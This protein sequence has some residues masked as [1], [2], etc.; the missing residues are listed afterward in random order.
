MA[1]HAGCNYCRLGKHP[2]TPLC[3]HL[4]SVCLPAR[5]AFS[6]RASESSSVQRSSLYYFPH[7]SWQI[8]KR[9]TQRRYLWIECVWALLDFLFCWADANTRSVVNFESSSFHGSNTRLFRFEITREKCVRRGWWKTCVTAEQRRQ[10]LLLQSMPLT[11]KCKYVRA[12]RCICHF[13]MKWMSEFKSIGLK[14]TWT[15]DGYILCW[16]IILAARASLSFNLL[17]GMPCVN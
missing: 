14:W 4:R 2:Q 17:A 3:M 15:L 1:T 12:E 9:Y 7:A 5:Y 8:P 13:A 10:D 6:M 11:V 16:Y